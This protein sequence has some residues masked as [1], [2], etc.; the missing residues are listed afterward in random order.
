ND[1]CADGRALTS[2]SRLSRLTTAY[3]DGDSDVHSA[4][5]VSLSG[6]L[7]V[8]GTLNIDNSI[9]DSRF[10]RLTIGGGLTNSGTINITTGGFRAGGSTITIAGTLSNPFG[11]INIDNDTT[12]AATV[13]S[14][15]DLVAGGT[16][17]L[18]GN[19]FG[20]G[21]AVMLNITNSVTATGDLELHTSAHVTT[22][23]GGL[24][25]SSK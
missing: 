24:T 25:N 2:N 22:S 17:A 21:G 13:G 11:T 4:A 3:C 12:S 6:G 20:D 19:R 16:I 15:T 7:S 9:D 23:S 1:V 5:L 10:S 14:A 18:R 8:G